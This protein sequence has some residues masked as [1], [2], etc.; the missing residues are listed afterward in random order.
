[1][2]RVSVVSPEATVSS[3]SA[4]MRSSIGIAISAVVLV[5]LPFVVP[6]YLVFQGTLLLVYA[7]ALLGL[8]ILVGYNGQLSLGHSAF[9]A[10]G[11]Y[12]AAIAMDRFGVP[13][14]LTLPLAASVC[15]VFGFLMGFPA[16]RLGSIYLALATFALALATPQLLKYKKIEAWTGGSQGIIL[17]KPEFPF[18]VSVAGVPITEDRWMYL[19]ALAV[20]GLL[21]WLAANLLRGRIGRA[22]IAIRDHPIAAAAMGIN[23][24]IVKST[25]FGISAAYTGVAGALSAMAIGFVSPDSYPG[26]LS[27]TML[28]GVV[29]GGLASIPGAFL[30]AIFILVVPDLADQI[31]KSAPSAIY[32]LLLIGVMLVMPTGIAGAI[33]HLWRSRLRRN[34]NN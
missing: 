29:V 17:N 34:Q 13:Y 15:F 28:V 30:G 12:C 4:S 19:L 11:A 10:I 32:G 24:P 18:N 2:S 33:Q 20:A 22:L 31:S 1:M 16:L 5:V 7:I 27:I 14:W 26:L 21:F 8:N 23:L 9:Y 3:R 25:T 6:D